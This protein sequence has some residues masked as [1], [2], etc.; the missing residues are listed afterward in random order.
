[1]LWEPPLHAFAAGNVPHLRKSPFLHL[2][3]FRAIDIPESSKK[4][5]T[6]FGTLISSSLLL[7]L[8][9]IFKWTL[10]QETQSKSRVHRV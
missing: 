1:M 10:L 5:P 7:K 2:V 9:F 6:I 3:A 8:K 4:T